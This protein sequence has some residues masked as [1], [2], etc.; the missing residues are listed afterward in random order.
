MN[1]E[2]KILSLNIGNPSLERAKRQCE[3]LK[4]RPEDIFVL[5][6][7]KCSGGCEY[8]ENFF[9]QYGFDLFSLNSDIEYDVSFPKSNTGDLGVMI[10]S[11]HKIT[12]SFNC[13]DSNSQY[14][15]RQLEVTIEIDGK[16]LKIVGLYVPSRNAEKHK[17]ERKQKFIKYIEKYIFVTDDANRIIAG[18]FNILSRD[19]LPHYNTFLSWEYD[20]YDHLKALGY[21]DA[22]SHCNPGVQD[23]SWVGRTND[24]YRYDYCFVH[25]SLLD[26]VTECF[27]IHETRLKRLTDHSAIVLTLSG[28]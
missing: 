2:I 8:I 6:E 13:F 25:S 11:K 15:S 10:V 27:F 3:W 4:E 21:E 24:G 7:T 14:Y 19:H 9:F 5:T 22:F 23:Y 18:D 16:P 12:H 17:I 20:F 26:Y 1:K 28:L